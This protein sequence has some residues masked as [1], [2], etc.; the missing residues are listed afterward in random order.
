MK[1]REVTLHV[2]RRPDRPARFYALLIRASEVTWERAGAAVPS[3]GFYALL[4]RAPELHRSGLISGSVSCLCSDDGGVAWSERI[5][6][7]VPGR[8]TLV[9]AGFVP[10]TRTV[11]GWGRAP[12]GRC[13]T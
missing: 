7:E 2:V 10:S 13:V 1:S 3:A 4:I 5:V 11:A 9:C 6:A 12:A 8:L